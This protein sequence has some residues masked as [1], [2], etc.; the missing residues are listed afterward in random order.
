MLS[1]DLRNLHSRLSDYADCGLVIDAPAMT[2]ICAVLRTAVDD[3]RALEACTVPAYARHTTDDLP[4]NVVR[5]TEV[6]L[7]GARPGQG[8]I[9]GPDNGPESAA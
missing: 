8:P 5:L 1:D 9:N 3:A 2:A 4:G 6:L 7:P